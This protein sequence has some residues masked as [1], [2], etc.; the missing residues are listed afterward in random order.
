M[1]G[2]LFEACTE[3]LETLNL[4]FIYFVYVRT[5]VRSEDNLQESVLFFHGVGPRTEV[6]SSGLA[7]P[8]ESSHCLPPL[9][10]VV[11]FMVE[12]EAKEWKRL[13]Q[14]GPPCAG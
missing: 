2:G 10:I 12:G 14:S 3:S 1:L 13:R 8:T 9:P 4:I 5:R 7:A 6:N 11:L